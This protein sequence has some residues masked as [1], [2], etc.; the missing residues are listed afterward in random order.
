M[1][2]KLIYQTVRVAHTTVLLHQLGNQQ[3]WITL[4]PSKETWIF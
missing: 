2:V 1:D 4:E 3:N